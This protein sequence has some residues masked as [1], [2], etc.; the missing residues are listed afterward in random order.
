MDG[1]ALKHNP[2]PNPGKA[3]LLPRQ[4]HSAFLFGSTALR[5]RTRLA[6]LEPNQPE[7]EPH[8]QNG[9]KRKPV[10]RD[11]FSK[12]VERDSTRVHLPEPPSYGKARQAT[13]S[14]GSPGWA[15][16]TWESHR[17][18]QRNV[19]R[20][21]EITAGLLSRTN[22]PSWVFLAPRRTEQEQGMGGRSSKPL[23]SQIH[24]PHLIHTAA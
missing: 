6:K 8:P 19:R 12:D 9:R 2:N 16:F 18:L 10:P 1:G 23:T 24:S 4:H 5:E 11:G 13:L 20:P 7:K 3:L 22:R 21:R 15:P 14:E 17:F